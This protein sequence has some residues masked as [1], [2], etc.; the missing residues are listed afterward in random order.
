MKN[1]R[2]LL[3]EDDSNSRFYFRRILAA[4]GYNVQTVN[5][6]KDALHLLRE[7]KYDLLITD[8]LMPEMD[9]IDLTKR[10][11]TQFDVQP[12]IIVLTAVSS[13]EA[14]KRALFAGADE[15]V[16]KPVEK[17][18][19]FRIITN[20]L[21]RQTL[22]SKV[23]SVPEFRTKS[24]TTF[25]GVCITASTG[26]PFTLASLVSKLDTNINAAYFIVQHGQE[27][28]LKTFADTLQDKTTMKV[29]LATHGMS[30][31]AG[32]IYLAPG[33]RH[34]VVSANSLSLELLDT[35]PVNFVKPSA[36]PLF[37]S[38]ANKFG[39]KSIGIVLTGMGRDGAIGSGY[40]SACGGKVIVQD[41][42]TAIL[43]SM[44][45]AVVK[46][47]LANRVCNVNMIPAVLK[48]YLH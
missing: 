18:K 1:F 36:D 7:D 37:K 33:N 39:N 5:N 6:G 19:L 30:V 42:S 26:G 13:E 27:W 28:M 41:P 22:T 38:V 24:S 16:A 45:E 2:I 15:Y 10:I 31:K 4:E 35:E 34:M 21:Q 8:W 23:T 29:E 17:D 25:F 40:I 43:P 48:S 32:N 12:L 9:G 11:R 46:L 47:N 44:P 3:V 14:K 20:L